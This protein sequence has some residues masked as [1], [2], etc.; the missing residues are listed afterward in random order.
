MCLIGKNHPAYYKPYDSTNKFYISNKSFPSF[1]KT[2]EVNQIFKIDY[3]CSINSYR[4]T[5][6]LNFANPD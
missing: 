3:P 2:A 5:S 1:L 6:I 4:P